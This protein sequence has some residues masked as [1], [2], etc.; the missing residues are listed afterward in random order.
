MAPRYGSGTF[1]D[2]DPGNTKK[3]ERRPQVNG[4]LTTSNS[5]ITPT[6]GYNRVGK[7]R[8]SC[9]ANAFTDTPMSVQNAGQYF[10]PLRG[11]YGKVDNGDGR[12]DDM[13]LYRRE[14]MVRSVAG[15]GDSSVTPGK[16]GTFSRTGD[17]R[18]G[19]PTSRSGGWGAIDD[20]DGRTDNMGTNKRGR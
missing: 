12:T 14:G 13:A 18:Q 17:N 5:A 10:G 11:G 6:P 2:R 4:S 20:G 15:K 9:G 8:N 7:Q 1:R 16:G 3:F 19:R